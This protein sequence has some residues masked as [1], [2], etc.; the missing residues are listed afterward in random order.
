MNH[1][2][3]TL[4]KLEEA[5]NQLRIS[6][7]MLLWLVRDGEI[8]YVNVGR[9][10]IRMRKMFTQQDIDQFVKRRKKSGI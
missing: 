7:R 9:G 4:L 3:R 2:D 1:N 10:K 5:A 8:P 6:L